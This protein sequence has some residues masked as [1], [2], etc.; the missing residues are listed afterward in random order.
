MHSGLVRLS[1]GSFLLAGVVFCLWWLGYYRFGLASP[2]PLYAGFYLAF[3][4]GLVFAFARASQRIG[5]RFGG[6]RLGIRVL[7]SVSMMLMLVSNI[8]GEAMLITWG[9]N[10][11]SPALPTDGTEE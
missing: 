2:V 3:G 4:L 10:T 5:Q 7:L 11:V 8:I 6:R 9:V 1:A